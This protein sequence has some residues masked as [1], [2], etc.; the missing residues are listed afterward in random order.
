MARILDIRLYESPK[1][2]P[3]A[4]QATNVRKLYTSLL[5]VLF[6]IA[7]GT[8]AYLYFSGQQTTG[9]IVESENIQPKPLPLPI[10]IKRLHLRW[11]DFVSGVLKTNPISVVS[12]G[13]EGFLCMIEGDNIGAAQR[14][15]ELIKT[16]SR[17]VLIID[18]LTVGNRVRFVLEGE[19][20]PSTDN[21]PGQPVPKFVRSQLMNMIDSISISRG[22][23]NPVHSTLSVDSIEGGERFRFVF[24]AA[25]NAG[26]VSFFFTDL[27][28]LQ[29]AIAPTALK[30]EFIDTIYA[31]RVIWDLY[32]IKPSI[33][34][35]QTTESEKTR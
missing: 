28:H 17:D 5:V 35:V 9:A 30:I 14:I 15:S 23:A 27:I 31:V 22:M 29:Y 6:F 25:G 33:Q 10:K 16:M 11:C 12:N 20:A 18:T 7:S 4:F 19:L 21:N 3:G 2:A 24:E 32:D 1:K 34:T 26:Q 13:E 8:G